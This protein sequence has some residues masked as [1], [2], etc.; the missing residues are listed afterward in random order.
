MVCYRRHG[1]NEADEPKF[2]QPVL[3]NKIDNHANP[4]EIYVQKLVE[5]G[6]VDKELATTMEKEFKALLQERL[7]MVKQK[8]LPYTLPKLEQQWSD[9]RPATPED[10]ESSPATGVSLENLQTVGKALT[11]IPEGFKALKQIDKLLKDRQA[12]IFDKQEVN[13][14]T[15]ELLAYG[16]ILLDGQS[17]R[18]SGQDVKRGTFSHRHAVLND[19][20]TN[21]PYSN[22]ANIQDEQGRFM[23]YNSLLSEYGV[24]G[25]EFG[26]AMANPQAL[27]IWEAQFGDFANGAQVMIDQFI[28]SAETKW[29]RWNG[30]VML[31]PH[32]YEGQGPEHSNARP[33]RYLQLCADNN[34]YVANVTTPANLFHIMRRQLALP[35]RKPLIVMSP[36]S[37]LRH[38][39]CVSPMEDLISGK[40]QET[41]ADTFAKPKKVKRILLCTG[42][43]YYEL[44]EKQQAEQRDD[45][46]IIRVEQLHPLPQKQLEALIA[47][48]SKTAK[49]FWVQEEP[50]N[51][52]GWTYMLRMFTSQKMEVIARRPSASPSTGF[53]KVHA[54]E[55]A[56]IIRRA[57]EE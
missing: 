7:D 53:S 50:F 13:W 34:M 26:Y 37:M 35:F 28:S 38:P 56:E 8:A 4:R 9:L 45:V 51:M 11:S 3:Y 2:T 40:F 27:V 18:I 44:L 43:I 17:V 32:G 33:E 54:K 41:I 30:L 57:F 52:G 23:I 36:K 5:R 10:F 24:L 55:Q 49:V 6:D 31:L 12:M 39:L 25:F 22:L 42:K 15:A 16:S 19:A 21:Q 1:H 14:A 20:T 46:A 29:N 47:Q 48:Y